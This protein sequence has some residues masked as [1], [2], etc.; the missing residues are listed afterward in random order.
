MLQKKLADELDSA[1]N[2][3]MHQERTAQEDLFHSIELSDSDEEPLE[4]AL[5]IMRDGLGD[6]YDD[7]YTW[8]VEDAQMKSLAEKVASS[9]FF[10][11][12]DD[13]PKTLQAETARMDI[14]WK[15]WL[16]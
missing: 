9:E 5:E 2:E 7:A 13:D 14:E 11:A 4:V 8:S 15:E 6:W 10:P 3:I 12:E 16:H 1:F